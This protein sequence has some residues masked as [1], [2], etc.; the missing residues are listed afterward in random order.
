VHFL[1]FF[2]HYYF[3][4]YLFR[5]K[6]RRIALGWDFPINYSGLGAEVVTSGRQALPGSHDFYGNR[7]GLIYYQV[8]GES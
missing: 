2:I 4:S 8:M 7:C 1:R 5:V 3:F 6:N